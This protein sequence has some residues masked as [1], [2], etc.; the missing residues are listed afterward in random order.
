MYQVKYLCLKL[1][2]FYYYYFFV[3]YLYNKHFLCGILYILTNIKCYYELFLF[4]TVNQ[5]ILV[6][7]TPFGNVNFMVCLQNLS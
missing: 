2:Q 3:V 1:V 5:E 4:C 6:T 7:V